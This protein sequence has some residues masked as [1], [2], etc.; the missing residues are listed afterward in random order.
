MTYQE[1]AGGGVLR[2]MPRVRG[3]QYAP[4]DAGKGM[5]DTVEKRY[6]QQKT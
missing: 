1:V 4:T 5:G 3:Y 2:M 6:L